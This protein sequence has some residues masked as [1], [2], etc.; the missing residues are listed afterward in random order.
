MKHTLPWNVTGIPPEVREIARAAALREGISVGEWLTRRITT[1]AGKLTGGE[2]QAPMA[3][4]VRSPR[5]DLHP[6][7]SDPVFR[8]ID[9]AFRNL[10]HRLE[11]TERAQTDAHRAM[12]AAAH[13]IN[14]ATRDQAEAFQSITTRI[15]RVERQTDTGALRDA[16]R[17]LHQ[18]LSRLAE[19]IAKTTNES[20]NGITAL[21]G[22]VEMLAGRMANAGEESQQ[23]ARALEERFAVL[24]ERIRDSEGRLKQTEERLAAALRSDGTVAMFQ[25]RLASTEQRMRES[26]DNSLSGFERSLKQMGERLQKTE[27]HDGSDN[28]IDE[29]LQTLAV[30]VG[31]MESRQSFPVLESAAG[32]TLS[33]IQAAV[34]GALPS[35]APDLAEFR[36]TPDASLAPAST[37]AAGMPPLAHEIDAPDCVGTIGDAKF[38]RADEVQP[39]RASAENFLAQARRAAMRATER[40]ASHGT[41]HRIGVPAGSGPGL[42]QRISQHAS[43]TFLFLVLM[44]A[45]FLL[46]RA[47]QNRAEVLAFD[48]SHLIALAAPASAGPMTA[49]EKTSAPAIPAAVPRQAV[50]SVAPALAAPADSVA[51]ASV[52]PFGAA[53]ETP[54]A[55]LLAKANSGDPKAAMSLGLEYAD[56]DG[57]AANDTEA[58]YWL[59][60]AAE[61]GEAVAQY[62]LGTLYERGRGVP[63]DT[64]QALHWYGEAAKRGNRRAMHNLAIVYADGAAADRNFPE[65]L[66]WFKDAAELGL[67][68]SQFNLAVLYERGL[69]VK[70]SLSEAY[71]WYEIAAASGDSQSKARVAA[72]MNQITPEDRDT[73]D[74]AARAYR[75]RP[76][77]LAANDG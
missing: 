17:G 29:A 62:R 2:P 33:L 38:H 22:N 27:M 1:D 32:D 54:L 12:R 72:L 77:D 35:G 56:G 28:R 48:P 75:P 51:S 14:A 41:R 5:E 9:E 68:D 50:E 69:G 20:S 31:A 47:V 26:L 15:D 63:A 30:R 74:K 55:Q 71:K 43:M 60:K 18:G 34:D 40:S 11:N 59:Q 23:N 13:E 46:T 52:L 66:R 6:D 45:G 70:P 73:A 76:I 24:D 39:A 61:A 57:V 44:G 58:F 16:V 36:L 8:R 3:S 4:P 10:A 42:R 67:T 65:A 19:Q 64:R 25:S 7:T 37:P 21:A 53:G 49:P